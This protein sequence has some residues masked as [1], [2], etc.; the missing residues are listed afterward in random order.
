MSERAVNDRQRTQVYVALYH[1]HIPKLVDAEIITF[2]EMAEMI[3]AAENATQTVQ[4]FQ[5]MD[6]TLDATQETH[7]QGEMGDHSN[8]NETNNGDRTIKPVTQRTQLAQRRYDP[9]EDSDLTTAIIFAL[10]K[11]KGVSPTDVTPLQLDEVAGAAAIEEVFFGPDISEKDWQ[12][13]GTVEFHVADYL[14]AVRS[15][16]WIQVYDTKNR[17]T[18]SSD[19]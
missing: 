9:D 6:T 13:S 8:Y 1:S 11:A 16:G 12:E 4:A 5:A 18:G 15:N 19:R 7:A 2:E 17:G 10:T 3:T 14:V